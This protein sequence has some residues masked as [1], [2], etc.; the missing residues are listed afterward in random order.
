[1]KNR[2]RDSLLL[3]R[4]PLSP[5]GP[6][7]SKMPVN[8]LLP[9]QFESRIFLLDTLV[10]VEY[11][12]TCQREQTTHWS[13]S[14]LD[15]LYP[16]S[17][18][19]SH[20]CQSTVAAC[21]RASTFRSRD[22]TFIADFKPVKDIILSLCFLLFLQA[23]H[24]LIPAL[25]CSMKRLPDSSSCFPNIPLCCEG[26]LE[27]GYSAKPCELERVRVAKS[28]ADEYGSLKRRFKS[29]SLDRTIVVEM[30]HFTYPSD[31]KSSERESLEHADPFSIGLDS[32]MKSGRTT[33]TASR[34]FRIL[35]PTILEPFS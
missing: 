13:P 28:L 16:V 33:T 30:I 8:K 25:S 26:K 9:G 35:A 31:D 27:R 14:F 19:Q 10:I 24:T 29:L 15:P 17:H 3:P 34:T 18:Q 4:D 11:L 32:L 21:S 2:S 23:T 1:M 12:P 20:F 6:F 5:A 7:V 22:S